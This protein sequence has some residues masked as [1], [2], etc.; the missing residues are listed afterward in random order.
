MFKDKMPYYIKNYKAV[1][2]PVGTSIHRELNRDEYY[3]V[4]LTEVLLNNKE[5]SI[6][7]PKLLEMVPS[8][9][10]YGSSVLLPY[11]IACKISPNGRRVLAVKDGNRTAAIYSDEEVELDLSFFDSSRKSEVQGYFVD[12]KGVGTKVNKS[13]IEEKL[14]RNAEEHG[15]KK[16]IQGYIQS[17]G[18]SIEII[19]G[20]DY[21]FE[22]PLGSQTIRN[23]FRGVSGIKRSEEYGLNVLYAPIAFVHF[24][25]KEA[26]DY[27]RDIEE[28]WNIR[29]RSQFSM[30]QVVRLMPSNLRGI[31]ITNASNSKL[32]EL[33]KLISDKA[34]DLEMLTERLAT[35]VISYSEIISRSTKRQGKETFW[36][37]TANIDIDYNWSQ[38]RLS[39]HFMK[40]IVLS[41]AGSTWSDEECF[42][43]IET[44]KE[45]EVLQHQKTYVTCLFADY[46][47]LIGSILYAKDV[48][49]NDNEIKQRGNYSDDAILTIS[50]AA[51]KSDLISLKDSRDNL[52]V[53]IHCPNPKIE[54]RRFLLP[55]SMLTVGKRQR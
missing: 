38:P 37:R 27:A 8:L 52:E 51:A 29:D 5:E 35:D 3:P 12:L 30:V 9:S 14:I 26:E 28:S 22:R 45:Y 10:K 21:E 19:T 13:G 46:V 33:C 18:E 55:K 16:E 25:P 44:A 1:F 39:W 23:A 32:I 41:L 42:C 4:E 36:L 54:D 15:I 53:N 20:R 40:D 34:E 17:S 31:Y 48:I 6:T 2:M 47:D 49:K 43:N 11:I 50:K 24:L 7:D